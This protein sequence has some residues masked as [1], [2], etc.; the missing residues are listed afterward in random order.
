MIRH[1]SPIVIRVLA[2][3]DFM[4]LIV[5]VRTIRFGLRLASSDIRVN[6]S[7]CAEKVGSAGLDNSVK[8]Y[9]S[10]RAILGIDVDFRKTIVLPNRFNWLRP[11]DTG[12]VAFDASRRNSG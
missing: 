3:K 1:V 9:V 11:P 8:K 12:C 5:C 2:V 4:L 10:P 7:A 6:K